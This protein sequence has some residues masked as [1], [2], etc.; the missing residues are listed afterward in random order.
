MMQSSSSSTP[1]NISKESGAYDLGDLDQAL[2]LYLDGQDQD[3]RQ[4]RPHTLNIFPSEPMH[5][6][7]SPKP[8]IIKGISSGSKKSSEPS[9]HRNYVQEPAKVVKREGNRKGHT[10]SSEQD[11]P[12]TSDPKVFQFILFF[13]ELNNYLCGVFLGGNA[14][15]GGEQGLPCTNI[16]SG[17]NFFSIKKKDEKHAA[18]FDMEYARWLEEHHHLMVEL[19]SAV[20]E[21]RPESELQILVDNSLAHYDQMIGLKSVAV[22]SDVFHIFSGMWRT[23]AERCFLWMGGVRPSELIKI[24]MNQVEPLTEQQ[25]VGIYGLQQST[26]EAEEAL[27]QGL[28][29]LNQSLTETIVCDTLTLPPNMNTFMAQM[30][31][32]I[33]KLSTLEGFV[34]QADSLRQQTLHR[35][36]QL[37]TTRQAARCFL[38]IGEYFHRLRALSSLW[39]TRPRHD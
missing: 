24:I 25:M 17:T 2:F 18:L 33:N 1:F 19:R 37:L 23:P 36:Q 15:A 32:A 14:N 26:Q 9:N 4:M 30:S 31:V 34:R 39:L 10:S 38:A 28:E 16:S 6:E 22:K 12:K 13:H 27:S 7:P 21:H 20:H 5:V 35:L 29:S 3:Q 11:G 8:S